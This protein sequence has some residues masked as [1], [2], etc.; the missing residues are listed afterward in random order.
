MLAMAEGLKDQSALFRHE[1]AFVMGQLQ[2]SAAVQAL[3]PVCN[4]VLVCGLL[5]LF[6]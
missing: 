5:L 1:V 3:I 6:L 2:H 4:L